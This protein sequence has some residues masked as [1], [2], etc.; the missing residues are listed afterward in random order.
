MNDKPNNMICTCCKKPETYL[1][2]FAKRFVDSHRKRIEALVTNNEK[3]AQKYL[4]M[5]IHDAWALVCKIL[6]EDETC[7]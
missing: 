5:Q 2:Y 3:E 7:T 1:E 6:P 4:E